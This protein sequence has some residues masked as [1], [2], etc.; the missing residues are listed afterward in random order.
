MMLKNQSNKRK[1]NHEFIGKLEKKNEYFKNQSIS[2]LN[3]S[4]Y[5]QSL[6]KFNEFG[7]FPKKGEQLRIIT[8]KLINSFDFIL[9][10]LNNEIINEIY[11]TSYRIGK[12]TVLQLDKLIN[13][14]K[15]K[16]LTILISNNF[17]R[18]APDV[19][20]NLTILKN[21]TLKVEDNHTKILLIKTDNNNYVVE[22]SGNLSINARI[23]QYCI[24]NN[25]DI[26]NFHK[27]WIDKI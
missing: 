4:V 25:I 22:G 12:K 9:A 7:G 21:T 6:S 26:Y 24:D 10:I 17:P 14:G 13:Q 3:N 23:E 15:I 27:N 2:I 1:T 19:W 18:F 8:K 11:L 5:F 16:H 20:N